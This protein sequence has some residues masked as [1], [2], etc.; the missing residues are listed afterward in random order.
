MPFVLFACLYLDLFAAVVLTSASR[1]CFRQDRLQR[2]SLW[3]VRLHAAFAIAFA[4]TYQA[5]DHS[6][7]SCKHGFQDGYEQLT[8]MK[9]RRFPAP[10]C[11]HPRQ[12]LQIIM[13]D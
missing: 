3:C 13:S 9:A 6:A 12:G 5:D 11:V 10:P 1:G 4:I 8:K 7:T 2:T